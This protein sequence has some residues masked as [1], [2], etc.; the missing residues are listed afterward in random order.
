MLPRGKMLEDSVE[1]KGKSLQDSVNL[2]QSRRDQIT[3]KPASQGHSL[4]EKPTRGK[5]TS[6]LTLGQGTS[7]AEEVNHSKRWLIRGI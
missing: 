2:G 4:K 7:R 6:R 5:V 3:P 1:K